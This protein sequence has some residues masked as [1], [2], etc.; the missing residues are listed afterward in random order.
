M[1]VVVMRMVIVVIMSAHGR[2]VAD[3]GGEG[4]GNVAL[5][6]GAAGR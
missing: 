6:R 1:P 2:Y 3:V 4:N 5:A